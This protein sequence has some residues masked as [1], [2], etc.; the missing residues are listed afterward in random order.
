MHMRPHCVQNEEMKFWARDLGRFVLV[1]S[2]QVPLVQWAAN[3]GGF[4][5]VGAQ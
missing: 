4:V 3:L 2:K 1:W 5:L